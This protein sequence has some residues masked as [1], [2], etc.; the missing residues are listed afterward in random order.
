M[1]AF[2]SATAAKLWSS[3]F[4]VRLQPQLKELYVFQLIFS[5]AHA[6]VTI[7]EP[8]FFY[9]EG[10]SL[11]F[12]AVYYALHYILYA[13]ALPL[14]GMFGARFG[15][16]RS[17]SLS[18]PIFVLY[19]LALAGIHSYSI[20]VYLAAVLLTA[21]KI[22]YWPAFHTDFASFADKHNRGTELSWMSLLQYGVGVLGPL[23]G[24]FVATYFGFPILFTVAAVLVVCS[25]AP[26]LRTTDGISARGAKYTDPWNIIRSSAHRHMVISMIGWGEN[27]IDL[28]FWPIFLFIVIG[29]TKTLGIVV[30]I[31][32][33]V[34][35]VFGFL[36]GE[37]SDRF[38][39][40]AVIRMN[41]PFMLVGYLLRPLAATIPIALFT[42]TLARLA[43]AGV[44][45][46]TMYRLYVLAGRSRNTLNFM[47]ASELALAIVKAVVATSL[48][49]VFAVLLPYQ[50][51]WVTFIAAAVLAFFYAAL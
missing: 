10:F 33:A 9:Q 39:P 26:M 7:F 36:V 47:V 40:R 37:M 42:D 11:S 29:S 22:F 21:H 32:A 34:M 30:S 25:A 49:I 3:A 4:A 23:V 51:F 46:P 1:S 17:I 6:L 45:L 5:F 43:Y 19:F 50:A 2:G 8:I 18:L 31:S 20:L 13:L 28:V 35:T 15:V 24:G 44:N 41:L 12:I 38:S 27:L 16:E 14:G 48:A